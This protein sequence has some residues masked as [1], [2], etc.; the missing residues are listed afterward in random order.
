MQLFA[1]MQCSDKKS[2]HAPSFLLLN[3]EDVYSFR[4][5][6]RKD[7]LWRSM[8]LLG[9]LSL[10]GSCGSVE[11]SVIFQ[12]EG[13]RFDP[14]LHVEVSLKWRWTPNCSRWHSQ[15]VWMWWGVLRSFLSILLPDTSTRDPSSTPRTESAFLMSQLSFG[16]LPQH[17]M[18]Y[19]MTLATSD[20]HLQW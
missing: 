6:G 7:F 1:I 16:L 20:H 12:S 15:W 8:L 5:A 3:R 9:G 13:W 2:H 11:Q 14:Q 4:A 17:T 10:P 18:A 19:K